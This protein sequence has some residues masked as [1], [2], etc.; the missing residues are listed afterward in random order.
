MEAARPAGHAGGA[1]PWTCS[2]RR[3]WLRSTSLRWAHAAGRRKRD[4][5]RPI[6]GSAVAC[7]PKWVLCLP[8]LLEA[9]FIGCGIDF[10]Y[11]YRYGSSVG[12]S[13]TIKKNRLG[14]EFSSIFGS[15]PNSQTLTPSPAAMADGAASSVLRVV[16]PRRRVMSSKEK[17]ISPLTY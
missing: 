11:G 12:V 2:T 14:I 10:G 8:L 4:R 15:P 1:P 9:V 6:F 3:P 16:R 17:S 13:L 5:A 7:N